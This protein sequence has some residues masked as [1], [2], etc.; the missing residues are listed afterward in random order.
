[1]RQIVLIHNGV[2]ANEAIESEGQ[3]KEL[4]IVEAQV[5]PEQ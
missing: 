5:V 4:K 1:M 3:V 2:S